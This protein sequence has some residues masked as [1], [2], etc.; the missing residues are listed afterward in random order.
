MQIIFNKELRYFFSSSVGYI[1][2]GIFILTTSILLWILPGNYNI[3]ENGYSNLN[4]L[5]FLAPWLFLF[6]CPAISM[7][8]FAEEKQNSTLELLLTKPI[9]RWK[10]VLGKFLAGWI[11]VIIS[12][13]PAIAW[14]LSVYFL[15]NP[16]GNIDNGEFWGS[17]LGLIFLSAIYIAIGMFASSFNNN[18]IAAFISAMFLCFLSFYGFE[19]IGSI[20]GTGDISFLIKQLGI[21]SHYD[22]ISRGLIDSRDI[23]YFFSSTLLFIW[24]TK[25]SIQNK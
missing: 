2:I 3:L 10:I 8:L 21:S 18:Q 12:L 13:I 5:F 4:G 20:I 1:I 7:R 9:N 11:L 14:Y 23:I 15:A 17:F 16:I 19:L 24:L 22:A 25:I 6:L